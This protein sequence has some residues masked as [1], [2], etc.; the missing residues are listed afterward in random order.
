MKFPKDILVIDF[1]GEVG[2]P[3]QVGA[4]L[5]DKETLAE[6][7]SFTSYIYAELEGKTLSKSGISQEALVSAP[8]IADVGDS[9]LDKFGTDI[10][11]ASWVA[12]GDIKN[13][14]LV[15]QSAGISFSKY[16]YH[17]LDIWPTAY[18]QLMKQGY[19]G[20]VGS[21]EIF[22]AYGKTPREKHDALEDCRI[23]ADILR[24][25]ITD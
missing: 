13:F 10:M 25:L 11:L 22:Q 4:V 8:S 20:G 19:T 15:M 17:I 23:A 24:K 2:K 5:I 18:I 14:E 9:I 7:D 1:E 21:E 6:K 16:D 3:V 12:N